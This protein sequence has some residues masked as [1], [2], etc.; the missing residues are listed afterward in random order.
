MMAGSFDISQSSDIPDVMVAEL[1]R[2]S[3]SHLSLSVVLSM[4]LTGE[5]S[6]LKGGENMWPT[7][8]ED[9]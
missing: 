3:Q 1:C 9:E 7:D 4:D 6:Q 2:L 5:D 8:G